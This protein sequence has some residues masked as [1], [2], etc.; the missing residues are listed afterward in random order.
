M[1]YS[2]FGHFCCSLFWFLS[3]YVD[4]ASLNNFYLQIQQ[5]R[6]PLSHHSRR[7]ESFTSLS[8]S[9]SSQDGPSTSISGA[10]KSFSQA[11]QSHRSGGHVEE[12]SQPERSRI[13]EESFGGN[14]SKS[15]YI[16]WKLRQPISFDRGIYEFV[17]IID[18]KQVEISRMT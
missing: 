15:E 12:A 9:K 10:H 1:R 8:E 4:C 13:W 17:L 6:D 18:V 2:N 5:W 7:C 11:E 16:L 3:Q 14:A